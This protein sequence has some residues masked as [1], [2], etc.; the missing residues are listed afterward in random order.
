MKSLER[1]FASGMAE[2]VGDG[3]RQQIRYV[4]SGGH[5]DKFTDPE[6]KVRA[7]F[8]A[9]LIFHYEYPPNRIALERVV[10]DR[11]PVDVADIVVFRDEGKTR[12]YAVFETKRDDISDAEFEQAIEQVCGNGTWAKFRADY[13]GVVAGLTRRFLDFTPKYGVLER[14][15]NIIA[16]LPRSYGRPEEFRF[17]KGD[18]KRDIRK[19][20]KG[21]LIS[22]IRKCHQTLWGGGRL[23]PP[24]AFSRVHAH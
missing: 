19:V 15:A 11:R 2:L 18:D 7:E 8:W 21:E 24:A 9:D 1:A 6:E 3:Q 10:P 5:T 13:V 16:D 20:E 14:E 12:P 23:S 4:A 22:T 17:Y